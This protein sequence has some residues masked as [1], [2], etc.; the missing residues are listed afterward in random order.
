MLIDNWTNSSIFCLGHFL[1]SK[2]LK[3]TLENNNNKKHPLKRNSNMCET[4][5][6]SRTHGLCTNDDYNYF[7]LIFCHSTTSCFPSLSTYFTVE[8]LGFLP[9]EGTR[10]S[11][12]KHFRVDL[13]QKHFVIGRN[14]RG[15]F[16][17]KHW[18]LSGLHFTVTRVLLDLGWNEA[19]VGIHS[20]SIS[21]LFSLKTVFLRNLQ[22]YRPTNDR[23]IK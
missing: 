4:V 22:L 3:S 10:W 16:S 20:T 17:V 13:C 12:V 18:S 1:Y 15:S 5:R 9:F 23:T 8:I 21:V 2:A 19:V 14:E 6:W 11:R 7:I